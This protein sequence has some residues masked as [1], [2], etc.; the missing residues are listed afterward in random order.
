[1]SKNK[2]LT[3]TTFETDGNAEEQTSQ[4][5][6]NNSHNQI[7]QE[8]STYS[9]ENAKNIIPRNNQYFL[10]RK[11]ISIHSEDRDINNH[12]DENHFAVNLPEKLANVYSLRL[13]D[14]VMPNAI[15]N[16]HHNYQNTK[17]A[18]KINV[19]NTNLN[20]VGYSV[21]SNQYL[22]NIP[23]TLTLENGYYTPQHLAYTLQAHMR[24]IVTQFIKTNTVTLASFQYN[25]IY[26]RYNENTG[27]FDFMNT[28]DKMELLFDYE[29][30]YEGCNTSFFS[31]TEHWGL[32]YLLGY[33]KKTYKDTDFTEVTTRIYSNSDDP[34]TPEIITPALTTYH[35]YSL[36]YL[37]SAPY[38]NRLYADNTIY[39]ELDKYNTLDEIQPYSTSTNGALDNKVI[40]NNTT[41]NDY[42]GKVNSAFA[43]IVLSRDGGY[44]VNNAGGSTIN[45]IIVFK[46]AVPTISKL[47]FKLRWHDGRLVEFEGQPI[48]LMIE[49]NQLIDDK[50][51]YNVRLASFYGL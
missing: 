20:D 42:N 36:L 5:M 21:L 19:S 10:D 50:A 3:L 51:D 44:T 6:L 18:W 41:K 37:A 31:Q 9:T 39:I 17:L 43:K 1:M 24:S 26:V 35:T 25:F 2:H 49:A 11:F 47:T 23:F 30:D 28:R 48:H 46:T 13:I 14:T 29:F 7:I 27:K 38:K 15:S 45:N 34:E 22:L 33:N 40:C 16:I 8:Q 4:T 32:P 12:P